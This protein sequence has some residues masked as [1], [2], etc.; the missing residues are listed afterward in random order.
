MHVTASGVVVGT[1]A[2]MAPEQAGGERVDP[3]SDLFSLGCVLYRLCTGQTPFRGRTAL[4]LLRALAVDTPRPPRERN[5]AVPPALNALILRLLE[6]EP[7]RRFDVSVADAACCNGWFG[8][9]LLLPKLPPP[10]PRHP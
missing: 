2:Y 3:R 1:P 7:G 8:P 6:K 5:P 10:L 9:E 4:A